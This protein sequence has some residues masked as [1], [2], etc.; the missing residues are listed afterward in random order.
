VAVVGGRSGAGRPKRPYS[1]H[2]LSAPRTKVKL[3]GLDALDKRTASARAVVAFRNDLVLD[4]GGED[5]LSTQQRAMVEMAARAWAL[6]GHVDVY[7]FE[8]ESL[9]DRRR[10]QLLPV[11]KERQA[12]ADHLSRLLGQLGLER[13]NPEKKDPWAKWRALPAAPAPVLDV[14]VGAVAGPGEEKAKPEGQ[15]PA[16]QE[17]VPGGG[18]DEAEVV[19]PVEEVQPA[20][21][22]V[23]TTPTDAER[24]ATAPRHEPYQEPKPAERCAYCR[25]SGVVGRGTVEAPKRPCFA[26]QPRIVAEPGDAGAHLAATRARMGR[27]ELAAEPSEFTDLVDEIDARDAEAAKVW[28]NR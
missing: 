15:A 17:I 12:L 2:G 25:G 22:P 3:R 23:A 20:P 16:A 5:D 11:L 1:R 8:R 28:G 14:P 24:W 19:P 26:C 13:K 21:P 27:V 9:V 18:E 10:K 6:L 7:L 4:L